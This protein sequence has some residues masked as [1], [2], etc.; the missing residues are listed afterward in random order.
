MSLLYERVYCGLSF[1]E[2]G[3]V[4]DANQ[5]RHHPVS[6]THDCLGVLVVRIDVAANMADSTIVPDLVKKRQEP[7][8]QDA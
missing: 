6:H 5:F 3:I 1:S 4:E 8:N 2:R 7:R